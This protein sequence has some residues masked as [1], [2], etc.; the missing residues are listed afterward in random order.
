[1]YV[2]DKYVAKCKYTEKINKYN[3]SLYKLLLCGLS[4]P[5]I[6]SKGHF[7]I[8]LSA[9]CSYTRVIISPWKFLFNGKLLLLRTV[10]AQ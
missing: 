5:N 10:I 1:M 7:L 4:F 2:P 3:F 8:D 9:D 6:I